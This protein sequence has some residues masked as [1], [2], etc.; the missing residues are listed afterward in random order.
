[1]SITGPPRWRR[2][3]CSG[4]DVVLIGGGNSAGQAAVYLASRA[5]KVHMLVRGPG[6][7]ATMSRNLIDRISAQHNI[8]LL[9]HTEVT[10]LKGE[11]GGAAKRGMDQPQ[12]RRRHRAADQPCLPVH[13]RRSQHRLAAAMRGRA[14]RQGL[15]LDHTDRPFQTSQPGVFSV[16]DARAGSIK[17]VAA[18]V[19]EG[20]QV[21]SAIHAYLADSATEKA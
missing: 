7:A 17:R 15:R 10:A 12:D 18:A 21:V 2:G 19:G 16:G 1:M 9:P 13:R 6:L 4:Q 5:R 11:N 14:R 8:E 20:A 3:L